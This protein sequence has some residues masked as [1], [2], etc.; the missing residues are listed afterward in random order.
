MVFPLP[1]R[2]NTN[3]A[4]FVDS[5]KFDRG[6]LCIHVTSGKGILGNVVQELRIVGGISSSGGCGCR[7]R[8]SRVG[9]WFPGSQL[10]LFFLTRSWDQVDSVFG[11]RAEKPRLATE[12]GMEG[13]GRPLAF[14][15]LA[16]FS[17]FGAVH[18][19]W[20]SRRTE[21]GSLIVSR[22]LCCP[23]RLLQHLPHR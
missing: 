3:L 21:I 18:K 8:F 6:R 19:S 20:G 13:R 12:G 9:E 10:S 11:R 22:S 7:L 5:G 16:G 15:L 1:E 2:E 4:A 23:T 17:V 14:H